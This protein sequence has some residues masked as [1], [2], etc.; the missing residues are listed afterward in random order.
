MNAFRRIMPMLWVAACC[1]PIFGE[2]EPGT[3]VRLRNG[4]FLSALPESISDGRMVFHPRWSL[5][6]LSIPLERL[7]HFQN[8]EAGGGDAAGI[9][10]LEL[11]NGDRL[12]LSELETGEAGVLRAE[13]PWGGR[14]R[15]PLGDARRIRLLP[16]NRLVR[17][18]PGFPENPG[19]GPSRIRRGAGDA[20]FAGRALL[21]GDSPQLVVDVPFLPERF[22]LELELAVDPADANYRLNLFNPVNGRSRQ[23]LMLQFNDRQVHAR[24]YEV[25]PNGRRVMQKWIRN[26][27]SEA[28]THHI[29]LVGD[30]PRN[31]IL[32][33]INDDI[34]QA[35]NLPMLDDDSL[36]GLSYFAIQRMSP[37]PIRLT[38]FELVEWD[39][40]PDASEALDFTEPEGHDR[41]VFYDGALAAGTLTGISESEIRFRPEGEKDARGY[42]RDK[43]YEIRLSDRPEPRRRATGPG[44][45]VALFAGRS[46]DRFRARLNRLEAGVMTL[47]RDGWPEP[48]EI[49][50]EAVQLLRFPEKIPD[51]GGG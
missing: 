21:G 23:Q 38:S 25:E 29:R 3:G 34:S 26:L 19:K 46:G 1:L 50:L 9:A 43:V 22:L 14:F 7:R 5:D 13:T 42:A 17:S 24:W 48:V 36:D 40:D 37:A 15:V 32:L 47:R 39:G 18:G 8:P 20:V 2:W 30:R 11:S 10:R 28:A 35:W 44:R 41:L 49:P 6:S 16:E 33:R 51:G 12:G 4:D 27:E 31:R 45:A